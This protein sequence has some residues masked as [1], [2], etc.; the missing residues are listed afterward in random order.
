MDPLR[1]GS[2]EVAHSFGG[3]ILTEAGVN[4]EVSAVVLSDVAEAARCHQAVR[5]SR[6]DGAVSAMD[7]A[8]PLTTSNSGS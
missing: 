2:G 8:A 3:M 7:L 4:P 6:N 5:T 1:L